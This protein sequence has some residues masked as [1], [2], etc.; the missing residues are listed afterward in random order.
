MKRVLTI[1]D[2]SCL[3]KCSLTIAL[4][5]LSAM[6][7]ETVVLPTALLSTHTMFQ[8]FT[9]RDLSD[10]I[11][12]IA[13]HWLRERMSFDA[14]Y[15][16]YLG[17]VEDIRKIRKL[18]RDFR[19]EDTR[20]VVDPAMADSGRL[21]PGF[22]WEYVENN[23]QLC[24]EADVILPNMTEAAFLTGTAYQE[25]CSEECAREL[26]EKLSERGGRITILTSVSLKAGM[27]GIMGYDR[28]T[29]EYYV[30]QHR[31]SEGSF[32]GTGD[33]FSCTF[34]GAMLKGRSWRDAA[35]IAAD[36]T[37]YTIEETLKDPDRR[38]YGVN[39]ENTISH[40]LANS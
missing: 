11:D 29:K 16:G 17:T 33:L 12:P 14:I 21:Y 32:C 38:W 7:A 9:F 37:V 36:Y 24:A 13:E 35:R 27:T 3:G 30:Y 6:G 19:R 1:Q 31:K 40:L 20:I 5:I 22:D 15:T 39:F 18:I 2:I 8:G 25:T 28:V 10:Q 26:L 34:T 23:A 4:P